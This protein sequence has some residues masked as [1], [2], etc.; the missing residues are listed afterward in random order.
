[1]A[2]G[3]LTPR[4]G[5]STSLAGLPSPPAAI[6]LLA[7]KPCWCC[8]LGEPGSPSMFSLSHKPVLP[9]CYGVGTIPTPHHVPPGLHLRGRH[10]IPPRPLPH[11]PFSRSLP[12]GKAP[13][14]CAP[15]WLLP[16]GKV[17]FPPPH[18]LRGRGEEEGKA[19]NSLV[20]SDRT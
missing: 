11:I 16:E 10:H 5:W 8:G 19:L 6:P 7:G 2:L 1:M 18:H 14:P 3:P 9:S 4:R 17:P 20:T 12:Q 13:F 15:S